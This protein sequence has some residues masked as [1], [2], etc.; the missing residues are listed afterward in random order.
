ML[1]PT[2]VPSVDRH[3]GCH[4]VRPDGLV[5]FF[6]GIPGEY[7][8]T[9]KLTHGALGALVPENRKTAG[10]QTHCVGSRGGAARHG[11]AWFKDL[12]GGPSTNQGAQFLHLGRWFGHGHPGVRRFLFRGRLLLRASGETQQASSEKCQTDR[13]HNRV[14]P[15]S[16]LAASNAA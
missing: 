1:S 13:L 8:M 6:V 4:R 12:V 10:T 9:R 16:N 2:F 7:T 14:S 11:R 3:T 5:C 15:C